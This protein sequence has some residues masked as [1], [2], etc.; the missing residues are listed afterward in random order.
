MKGTTAEEPV[1]PGAES[2]MKNHIM[3]AQTSRAGQ[4]W[5][6]E[7]MHKE[8]AAEKLTRQIQSSAENTMCQVAL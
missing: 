3:A 5:G 2:R 1:V 6:G 8:T 7:N 4:G